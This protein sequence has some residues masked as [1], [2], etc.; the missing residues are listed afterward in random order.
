MLDKATFQNQKARVC[1]LGGILEFDVCSG[2]GIIAG[3]NTLRMSIF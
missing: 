3:I 2:T 1:H